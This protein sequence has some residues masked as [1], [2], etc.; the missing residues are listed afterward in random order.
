MV[1]TSAP[2]WQ[3][4]IRLTMYSDNWQTYW[5]VSTFEQ[6]RRQQ[7]RYY[8][9]CDEVVERATSDDGKLT[10]WGYHCKYCQVI[11]EWQRTRRKCMRATEW[12]YYKSSHNSCINGI[13]KERTVSNPF[14]EFLFS[15]H[16]R[17][18]QGIKKW[19][20]TSLGMFDQRTSNWFWMS[21][22]HR[23]EIAKYFREWQNGKFEAQVLIVTN[24]DYGTTLW[25]VSLFCPTTGIW[26]LW[27][28]HN[29]TH[30]QH[31]VDDTWY[32]TVKVVIMRIHSHHSFWRLSIQ[33]RLRRIEFG[34]TWSCF[35]HVNTDVI[36][37]AYY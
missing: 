30:P 10:Q 33:N 37:V 17:N 31:I 35:R 3:M 7:S 21:I 15:F 28:Y 18:S 24:D 12:L 20:L 13:I 5:S 32:Q 23:F 16:S 8:S 4:K 27:F 34:Y 19:S 1:W 9:S 26:R 6:Y 25:A 14:Q 22:C 29:I 2:W 36:D 11:N